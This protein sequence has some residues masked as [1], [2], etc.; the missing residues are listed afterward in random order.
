MTSAQYLP[1]ILSLTNKNIQRDKKK[2]IHSWTNN[3]IKKTGKEGHLA[4]NKVARPRPRRDGDTPHAQFLL[5]F[6]DKLSQNLT[7]HRLQN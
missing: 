7:G 4:T 5:S 3:H 1:H 2:T 6:T